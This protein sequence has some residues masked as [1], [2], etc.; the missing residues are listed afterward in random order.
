MHGRLGGG[1]YLERLVPTFAA[2]SLLPLGEG[3]GMSSEFISRTLTIRWLLSLS[4]HPNPLP[5]GEGLNLNPPQT[6]SLG[7][8]GLNARSAETVRQPQP[9]SGILLHR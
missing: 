5:E 1:P 3:S 6:H 9:A 7:G 2:G 8:R 4:P